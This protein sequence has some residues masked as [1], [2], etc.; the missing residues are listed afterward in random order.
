MIRLRNGLGWLD[1]ASGRCADVPQPVAVIAYGTGISFDDRDHARIEALLAPYVAHVAFLHSEAMGS[2]VVDGSG[3][4]LVLAIAAAT[5]KA[6]GGWDESDAIVL[7]VGSTAIAVRLRLVG[8]AWE[9][10]ATALGGG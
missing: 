2:G 8:G 4:P 6:L 5:L 3:P 1:L 9:A 7:R 10:D